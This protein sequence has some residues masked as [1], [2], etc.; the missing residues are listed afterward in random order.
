VSL[1]EKTTS[2]LSSPRRLSFEVCPKSRNMMTTPIQRSHN[3]NIF[4]LWCGL[5]PPLKQALLLVIWR[6]A[7]DEAALTLA[8]FYMQKSHKYNM[9]LL[10]CDR[11]RHLTKTPPRPSPLLVGSVRF[12]VSAQIK[13]QDDHSHS[14]DS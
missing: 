10:C 9:F 6:I 8:T 1:K 7:G 11:F 13:K 12:L 2:T 4:L 14:K 5:L 3:R